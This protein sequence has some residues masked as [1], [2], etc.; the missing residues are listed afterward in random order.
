M[1]KHIFT[2]I[3]PK[4]L[5]ENPDCNLQTNQLFKEMLSNDDLFEVKGMYEEIRK[6][7]Q[8]IE[9]LNNDIK[10][11]VVKRPWFDASNSSGFTWKD[12]GEFTSLEEWEQSIRHKLHETNTEIQELIN[13]SDWKYYEEKYKSFTQNNFL[14]EVGKIFEF[15][16]KYNVCNLE[17]N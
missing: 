11:G 7:E 15:L 6:N 9:F 10:T 3:M 14:E 16:S 4:E 13:S 1:K 12:Y 17:I 2:L 5:C 8:F